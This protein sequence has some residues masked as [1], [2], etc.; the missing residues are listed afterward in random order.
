MYLKHLLPALFSFS[1]AGGPYFNGTN[2]LAPLSM[3]SKEQWTGRRR[4]AGSSKSAAKLTYLPPNHS[5]GRKLV[6]LRSEKDC[7]LARKWQ[8]RDPLREPAEREDLRALLMSDQ[9]QPLPPG[10]RSNNKALLDQLEWMISGFR[11]NIAKSEAN[12]ATLIDKKLEKSCL[13]LSLADLLV[14]NLPSPPSGMIYV[15]N[16]KRSCW[17]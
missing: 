2:S 12:T 11:E 5:H 16:E 9:S 8:V 14:R 3:D 15:Q 10:K 13:T 1:L 6:P 7:D 17:D 4:L